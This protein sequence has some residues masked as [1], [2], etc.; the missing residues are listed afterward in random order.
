MLTIR[1]ITIDDAAAFLDLCLTLDHETPFMMYEPGERTTT[2]DQQRDFISDM[3]ASPNSTIIVAA[4]GEQLVGYVDATGGEF[5]RIRH[6]AYVVAGVRREFAGKGFGKQ[7]FSALDA[8][9]VANAIQRLELT[10]RIDNTAA[11]R[12]YKGMGYDIEGTKRQS[13]HVAGDFID[14]FYMAKLFDQSA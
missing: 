8:W 3:I 4:A 10:V 12:L 7:L 2:V 11:I 1:D 13:L 9:A 5:N 14:E 6:S